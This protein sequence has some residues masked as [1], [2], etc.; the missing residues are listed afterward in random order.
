MRR[1]IAITLAAST[2]AGT[3]VL[4]AP[5]TAQSSSSPDPAA[6]RKLVGSIPAAQHDQCQLVDP[7]TEGPIVEAEASSIRAMVVCYSVNHLN[8][9]WYVLMD[10]VQSTNRLYREQVGAP[11]PSAPYRDENA[12]CPGETT[13]G[14]GDTK[15]DGLVA[16]YYSGADAGGTTHGDSIVLVW[17]YTVGTIVALAETSY[18]DSDTSAL[19]RWWNDNAGPLA[20][21][22][23]VK[24][25]VDWTVRDRRAE[26][27]L[28]THVPR[29]IRGSCLVK[30]R[31]PSSPFSGSRFFVS[32]VV[33]C[34][35]GNVSVA[36]ASMNPAI[37]QGFVQE[38]TPV[39]EGDPCP[40]AGTWSAGTGKKK[41]TVGDYA[42][43]T[44]NNLDGSQTAQIVWS[45]R[46]ARHHRVG[47]APPGEQ[48][49]GRTVAVVERQRRS[50]VIED[51]GSPHRAPLSRR[52]D[53]HAS[54]TSPWPRAR[55]LR[56]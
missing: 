16:C 4:A 6:V 35:S 49:H 56:G 37:V 39:D 7:V 30:D 48:R 32:A 52:S 21:P 18:G 11:D 44:A 23:P 10:S 15:D 53:R 25:F 47:V 27:A 40:A 28:L 51:C 22:G 17:T 9:L 31:S 36:Y 3:L 20:R 14:F 54:P 50:R 34:T 42:C 33:S 43:F 45:Q 55:H 12:Q 38:F 5:A 46:R 26:H 24:G 41:H 1:W 2:V 13:W 8:N 19:K 29:A